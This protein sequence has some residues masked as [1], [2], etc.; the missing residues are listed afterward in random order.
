M[1]LSFGHAG[2]QRQH[3]AR[4]IE[5]L[6][7][8]LLIDTEDDRFGGR[9]QIQPDD[10]AQLL[11]KLRVLRQFEASYPMRLQAVL[12]PNLP[13]RAVA[14]ALC[15]RQRATA[16]VRARRRP[17][18]QRGLHD[19]LHLLGTDL[20]AAAWT[21]RHRAA[22]PARPRSRTGPPTSAPSSG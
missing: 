17:R 14:Q 10:V 20:F 15:L 8:A 18:C 22:V 1:R 6:N 19:G 11:D 5:R 16:P 9:I 21:G 2:A 4:A 3:G 7:P 13:D 12:S